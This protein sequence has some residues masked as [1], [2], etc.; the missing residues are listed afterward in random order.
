MIC[1]KIRRRLGRYGKIEDMKMRAFYKGKRV[2][3]TGHTGFKGAWLS[4]WLRELGAKVLGYA[5]QPYT[6]GDIFVVSGLD[7]KIE[8]T[9][10]D[11]RDYKKVAEVF[12]SFKPE[13]VFHLAAQPLVLDSYKN[14]RETYEINV[15]GTVNVLES[16]RFCDSTKVIINVTTDKCYENLGEGHKYSEGDRLGGYDPY[17]SSKACSEIVTSS[18]RSSF[19][20]PES[21]SQHRKSLSSVRAG[22]IIGG[23]DWRDNRIVPDCV[24]A[25]KNAQPISVR[26]PHAVRPWQYVLEPLR[27]Y[28]TLALKM[29]EEPRHY[30]GAWNFG[31]GSS[32]EIS[33]SSLVKKI[34]QHWE[35]GIWEC[36]PDSQDLHEADIL[37]LDVEKVKK[38][39]GWKAVL[40]IDEAVEYTMR[41]YKEKNPDYDFCV[42]MIKD[43]ENQ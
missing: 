31:P 42:E 26:N 10:G 35:G 38:L 13:I 34:I 25:L 8:H 41:W 14:P 36:A 1:G 17:S 27:G 24:R 11:I 15:G 29:H 40:S 20:N 19:L 18:Y 33:V 16:C 9:I 28:L 4:T 7:K 37:R 5:L 39:L 3:V 23:G 2:L 12:D 32:S 21:F 30:C 6:E 43:Y 22:N